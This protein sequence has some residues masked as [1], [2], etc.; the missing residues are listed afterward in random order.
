MERRIKMANKKAS[1][2]KTKKQGTKTKTEVKE[3]FTVEEKKK[4]EKQTLKKS[5][6]KENNS[7]EMIFKFFEFFDKYK[8]AIY[9]LVGGVLA[10]VFV[11]MLIWPDRIAKLE[12][13]TEPV[14]TIDGMT[15]TADDLYEEMKKVYSITSLVD[16]IDNKILTEKYPETDEMKEEINTQAENYYSVYEQYYQYTKEEF[17]ANNN[18]SSEEEFLD[19]LKLSYRRNKYAEDYAKSLVT[20]KEINDYYDKEV[21]G[22]VN[23]KHMLVKVDSSATDEEKKAAEDTA[24]EII[25]KLNSGKTFDEVKEEYKD[26]V[27]YEELGYKAYNAN[28]ESAYKEEMR[29]LANDSYSK[30]PI[31]T[32]YGYHIVYRIDQKDK[33]A[34][35]DIKE[36]ILE[37]LGNQKLTADT[38]LSQECLKELRKEYNLKFTDT[39]LEKKYNAY[40]NI[41]N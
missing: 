13:G 34:L 35:E 24:K 3:T 26:K 21:Y 18:F 17:L 37:E 7:D 14:A 25:E 32:S 40:I 22:D 12:D 39:A 6:K 31:K 28:L 5:S 29:S 1:A 8:L 9:G 36:E 11:V 16:K 38:N 30:T 27:T 4:E 15:I 2:S 41:L 33:P 10:T 20:E 23:T 19:F